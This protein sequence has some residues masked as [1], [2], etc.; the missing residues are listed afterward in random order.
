M[1]GFESRPIVGIELPRIDERHAPAMH[2]E[3]DRH[4]FGRVRGSE[5]DVAQVR[6]QGFASLQDFVGLGVHVQRESDISAQFVGDDV[7]GGFEDAGDGGRGAAL[8][9]EPRHLRTERVE[10]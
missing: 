3:T 8:V 4:L 9:T 5:T 7:E 1:I 6:R 10:V 2:P